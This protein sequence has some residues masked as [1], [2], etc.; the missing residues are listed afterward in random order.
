MNSFERF[1]EKKFPARKCFYSSTKDGK[2]EDDGKILEGHISLK[3]CLMREKI[4]NRFDI[5]DMGDYH[6]RYFKKRCIVIS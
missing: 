3:D 5:K 4:W 6:D 2:I 1:N